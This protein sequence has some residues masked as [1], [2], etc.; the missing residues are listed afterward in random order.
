MP[1]T[2]GVLGLKCY[3]KQRPMMSVRHGGI[4]FLDIRYPS[5]CN[6]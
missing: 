3:F 2:I 4:T 1:L 6:K 5:K